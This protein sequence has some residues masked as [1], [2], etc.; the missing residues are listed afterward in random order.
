MQLVMT[1][2]RNTDDL[3]A[4][5]AR[6]CMV[7]GID[8]VP[9]GHVRLETRFKYPDRSSVD[10][11]IQNPTQTGERLVLTDLGQTTLWLNDLQV[12]PWQSKKRSRFIEDALHVL[13]IR[14]AGGAFEVDFQMSQ[15]SLMDA[16]VRLGQACVRVADLT[17]TR[18][19]TQQVYAGEEL[20]EII[21]DAELL[22]ETDAPLAGRH[23]IVIQ[24]DFLV[25]GR[26]RDSAVL[27][28]GSQTQTSAHATSIEVFRKMY[29]LKV[30]DRTEQLVAVFDDR[31]HELYR[32]EDLNRL[33][34]V[35]EV[36]PLSQKRDIQAA[37]AV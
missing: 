1:N 36:F 3:R 14:Q 24:V 35:S 30:P 4:L 18:R 19:S 32:P 6:V 34:E 33:S 2:P 10:L 20:E 9:R 15:E 7:K 11:F 28:L 27:T 17:F 37:L 21:S 22:Y 8:T 13:E 25:H 16:V 23:G 12:R 29:D 26:R 5:A 31:F